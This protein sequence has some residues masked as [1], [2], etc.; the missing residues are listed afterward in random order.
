VAFALVN[1]GVVDG[2]SLTIPAATAGNLLAAFV[3]QNGATLPGNPPT[4]A[5]WATSGSYATTTASTGVFLLTKTA[6]GGETTIAPTA[7]TGGTIDAISYFEISGYPGTLYLDGSPITASNISSATTYTSAPVT[8]VVAGSILLMC[9][10]T[11]TNQDGGQL[12]WAA[13]NLAVPVLVGASGTN[14]KQ[15]SASYIPGVTL[16]GVTF[17]ASWTTSRV[18]GF[19]L[20]AI[21]PTLPPASGIPPAFL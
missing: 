21:S 3:T 9:S 7:G 16:S 20:F 15:T 4:L 6:A 18:S 5:G 11:G 14:L 2:T 19:L 1:S 12:A 13:S 10:T 17:T 8:T